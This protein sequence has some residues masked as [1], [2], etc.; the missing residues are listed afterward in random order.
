MLSLAPIGGGTKQHVEWRGGRTAD[1]RALS[2]VLEA[3]TC[4]PGSPGP[5]QEDCGH[6]VACGETSAKSRQES[7][8]LRVPGQQA[9]AARTDLSGRTN[10]RVWRGIEACLTHSL[11]LGTLREQDG[12]HDNMTQVGCKSVV[13]P[14]LRVLPVLGRGDSRTDAIPSSSLSPQLRALCSV[15]VNT[16]SQWTNCDM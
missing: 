9:R 8:G 14:A 10:G 3:N 12:H 2:A 4:T 11:F 6:M 16:V 7:C 15:R 1:G 5:A 13:T